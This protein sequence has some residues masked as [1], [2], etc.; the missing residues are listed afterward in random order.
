MKSMTVVGNTQCIQVKPWLFAAGTGSAAAA[1][2]SSRV[3]TRFCS[4]NQQQKVP[5]VS[6]ETAEDLRIQITALQGQVIDLTVQAADSLAT[7]V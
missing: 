6:Q 2:S 3:S 4:K 1:K 5:E 7:R